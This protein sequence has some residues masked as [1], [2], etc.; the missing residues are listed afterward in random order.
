[1]G[2]L[3]LISTFFVRTPNAVR[4]P[5][6]ARDLTRPPLLMLRPA[7]DADVLTAA[8]RLPGQ[9]DCRRAIE[10]EA[11]QVETSEPQRG[12]VKIFP[13]LGASNRFGVS[14]GVFFS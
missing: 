2:F 3:Y 11:M 10:S 7:V 6:A 8:P 14:H 13:D 4:A 1:M 5:T 9:L 12:V